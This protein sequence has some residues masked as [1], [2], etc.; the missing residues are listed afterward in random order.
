MEFASLEKFSSKQNTLDTV[1][2]ILTHVERYFVVLIQIGVF[3]QKMVCQI[4]VEKKLL[5]FKNQAS[6]LYT[7][8]PKYK[9]LYF[10]I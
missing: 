9:L 6:I 5:V 3:D 8:Y 7:I 1:N 2:Y 4:N 10:S